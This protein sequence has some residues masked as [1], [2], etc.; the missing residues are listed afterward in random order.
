MLKQFNVY[1]NPS[2]A[3]SKIWP[4]YIIIQNDCYEDLTTRTIVPLMQNRSLSLWHRHIAPKINIEF[5][6]WVLYAPMITNLNI[7]KINHNDFVCNLKSAR[8]DVVAAVD[9]LITGI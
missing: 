6:T 7:L 8:H 1:R 3:T 9:A 4:Y 2:P 5:D